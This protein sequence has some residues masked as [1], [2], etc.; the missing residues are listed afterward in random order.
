MEMEAFETARIN[1]DKN[2]DGRFYFGVKT[3][4]I[5][6]RPSCPAPVAKNENV[7]YFSSIYEALEQKYVPCY[8][9][10]PDLDVNY[11][12][13]NPEQN[14]NVSIALDMIHA[15]YLNS[16]TVTDLANEF[17]LSER[18]LRKLFVDHLGI[19]PNKV[20]TFHRALFAKKLLYDSEMSSTN[21]AFAAGYNSIR[22]FNEAIKMYFGKTPSQLRKFTEKGLLKHCLLKVNYQPPF[23]FSQILKFMKPRLIPGIERIAGQS[24]LR[25]FETKTATGVF[26]VSDCP[27]SKYLAV[28]IHCDDFRCAMDINNTVRRMFDIDSDISRIKETLMLD[29]CFSDLFYNT[30]LPRIPKAYSVYEFLIRAII[31]QQISVKA[32]T[33]ITGKIVKLA[34]ITSGKEKVPFLFPD[35]AKIL[36]LDLSSTGLTEKRITTIRDVSK[37]ILSGK[38]SVN[39]YQPFN[40]FKSEFCSIKG[41][42]DWT[43]QY[44]G[45]RAMGYTDCFPSTDLGIRKAMKQLFNKNTPK[46]ICALSE[47]WR[48]YRSYVSFCLWNIPKGLKE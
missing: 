36:E 6:C 1:K 8:R 25:S 45:M 20:A 44:A 14:K 35:P 2:Y 4:N 7:V 9:C 30:T 16:N 41:I 31:G 17:D 12:R 48:P 43:A 46:E 39:R 24:Y 34:G 10:R 28:A 38:L 23:N 33:T 15:G 27:D 19:S 42:G 29:T 3:T 40:K 32:A 26:E 37:A 21:I 18:H 22:Q 13:G 11:Y 5:F 47:N